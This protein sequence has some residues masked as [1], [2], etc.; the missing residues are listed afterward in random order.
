M[1]TLGLLENCH[2]TFETRALR[3][4]SEG[5]GLAHPLLA[6]MGRPGQEGGRVAEPGRPPSAERPQPSAEGRNIGA[7]A[8]ESERGFIW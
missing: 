2:S 8:Y 4:S 3:L 7:S 5:P 6:P 1:R